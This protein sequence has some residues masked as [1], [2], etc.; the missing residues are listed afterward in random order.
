MNT[1]K[2][3]F[4]RWLINMSI[5]MG[6]FQGLEEWDMPISAMIALFIAFV[7]MFDY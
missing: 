2:S 1:I 4:K 7:L 3:A 6:R 5:G